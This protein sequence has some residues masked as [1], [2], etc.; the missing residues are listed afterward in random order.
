MFFHTHV[1]YAKQVD[2]AVDNLTIIGSIIPDL[3]LTSIIN[4]D[5]LHKKN[6][7]EAFRDYVK[8]TDPAYLPLIT[9]IN[10]HNTVDGLSH[11]QYKETIGYAYQNVSP[12]L[13]ALLTQAFSIDE[14]AAR[15]KG[16]NFIESGVEM[17]TLQDN[18]DLPSL[19]KQ[20]IANTDTN[21]LAILL[22]SF[23]KKDP[24]E[25]HKSL[26][27]YFSLATKYNL[28]DTNDWLILWNEISKLQF[29]REANEVKVREALQLSSETTKDTYKVFLETAL[30][31]KETDIKDSN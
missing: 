29:G 22:A 30:A 1:F 25:M 14:Q 16:H 27:M 8:N 15:V 31:L 12:E 19:L 28:N 17:H 5:A 18:Q 11:L 4:W 13:I 6:D 3:A 20:A 10:Y 7:I 24:E 23:H 2:P 21:K 26:E 9:G